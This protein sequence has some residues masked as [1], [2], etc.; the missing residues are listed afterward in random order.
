MQMS[1]INRAYATQHITIKY[2][3]YIL[4]LHET[5]KD[6]MAELKS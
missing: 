1:K 3:K 6:S 5:T 2:L 4:Q